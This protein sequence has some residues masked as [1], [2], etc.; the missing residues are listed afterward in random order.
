MKVM[1]LSLHSTNYYNFKASLK[2]LITLLITCLFIDI[3][4]LISL[5]I[6]CYSNSNVNSFFYKLE[7]FT[8]VA[9]GVL[10]L[11]SSS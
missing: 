11:W 4:K 7:K 5:L 6:L 8:T 2:V 1:W 10:A 3:S 9:L